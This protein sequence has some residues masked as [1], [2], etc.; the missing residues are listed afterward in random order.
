MFKNS[1]KTCKAGDKIVI[2]CLF[3]REIE[4]PKSTLDNN[5]VDYF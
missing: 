5:T 4:S 2:Y 1:F 3:A